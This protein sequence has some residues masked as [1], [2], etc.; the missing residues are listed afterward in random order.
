MFAFLQR[1]ATVFDFFMLFLCAFALRALVLFAYIQYNE[2]YCQPDS[3]DY[4]VSAFCLT[5]GFGMTRPDTGQPIFWRTP[6]YPWFLKFFYDKNMCT[7]DFSAHHWI[8]KK[9]LFVQVALCSMLPLLCYWLAWI[10]T[11]SFVISWLCAVIGMIHPGFIL[12]S[13]FLLTDGI[14]QLFFMLFLIFFFQLFS[15]CGEKILRWLS[16]TSTVIIAALSLAIYTWMRP[17][18]QFVML[19]AVLLLLCSRQ[20][21]FKKLL[22][23]GSFVGL[24]FVAISPWFYRNYQLT[25]KLFFCPLF[26]LYF[27][28]FN[29]PK[30][31]ARTTNIPL[32]DAHSQ[33]TQQAGKIIWQEMQWRKLSGNKKI[34]CQELMCLQTAW[35]HIAAHPFY[36][37]YDWTVEVIKTTF[38]LYTYQLVSLVHNCFKWDPL[39]EYLPEK[40][41]DAL[42]KKE[43]PFFARLLAWLELIFNLFLWIGIFAGI[44]KYIIVALWQRSLTCP[45]QTALWLKCGLMVIA[46]VAQTGGFGYARLRLPV[47]MLIIITG[48]SYWI[49]KRE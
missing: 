42:Y 34:V 26:G 32:K 38:D 28:V 20:N 27:N 25:G 31:L 16:F 24:F 37:M 1:K 46:V 2:R 29:A 39:V 6:G 48:L 21:W 11:S 40:L 35:P 45:A 19:F 23:S 13:N 30:I 14:A 5:H 17:M 47:E 4:H 41:Q 12:A 49:T 18:G 15:L 3:M 7:S 9:A 8:H 43:L 10:L 33:L 44:W 22:I 36:F